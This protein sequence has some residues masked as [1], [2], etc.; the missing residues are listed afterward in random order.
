VISQ[1]DVPHEGPVRVTVKPDDGSAERTII[2]K[3]GAEIAVANM[4]RAYD[5]PTS[6]ENGN[7]FKLYE[8]LSSRPVTLT[9][10]RTLPELPGSSS[11]HVLFSKRRP[12]GLYVDC[13]NTGCCSG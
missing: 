8:K 11:R 9:V 7:H 2:A 5:E 4:A 12:I 10:P 13:T 3:P 1:L 6:E